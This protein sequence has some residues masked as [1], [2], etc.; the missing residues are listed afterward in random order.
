[1]MF[2]IKII[3][4]LRGELGTNSKECTI[5]PWHTTIYFPQTFIY[6]I[7]LHLSVWRLPKHCIILLR[8]YRSALIVPFP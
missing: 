7:V 8:R 6:T 5:I 4:S 1:M 3:L 2:W